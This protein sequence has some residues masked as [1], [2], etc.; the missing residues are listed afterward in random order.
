MTSIGVGIGVG[1]GC[2]GRS[3]NIQTALAILASKGGFLVNGSNVTESGGRVTALTDQAGNYT[4]ARQ[5]GDTGAVLGTLGGV[6]VLDVEATGETAR[7]LVARTAG[8]STAQSWSLFVVWA[9]ESSPDAILLNCDTSPARS[10]CTNYVASLGSAGPCIAG[11]GATYVSAATDATP[12]VLE[13][14]FDALTSTKYVLRDGTITGTAAVYTPANLGQNFTINHDT[15]KLDGK[16]GDMILVE[17]ALTA[18][19]RLTITGYLRARY[20]AVL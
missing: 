14:V 11:S 16:L 18:G 10:L 6:P 3:A 7:Y 17:G 2:G 5:A 1:F 20:A 4:I 9:P 8:A 15:T 13:Y 19:E 12:Q